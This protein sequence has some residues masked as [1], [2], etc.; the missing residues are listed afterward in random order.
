MNICPSCCH[1]VVIMPSWKCGACILS[2]C[3]HET[4]EPV[5]CHHAVMK[6]WSLYFVIMLSWNCGACIL[7]PFCVRCRFLATL[8]YQTAKNHVI[9]L[10]KVNTH[11]RNIR[12]RYLIHLFEVRQI[13][14]AIYNN[15]LYTFFIL[16]VYTAAVSSDSCKRPCTSL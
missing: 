3:C 10:H 6:V 12:R 13:F 8:K 14:S 11:S 16:L 1:P 2:S 9:I 15:F 4:V 5:F 7:W